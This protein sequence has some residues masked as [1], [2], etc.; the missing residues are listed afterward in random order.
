MR[1]RSRKSVDRVNNFDLTSVVEFETPAKLKITR[2]GFCGSCIF[3]SII[4]HL[5]RQMA[6]KSLLYYLVLLTSL[7]ID[8]FKK[9]AL[10]MSESLLVYSSMLWLGWNNNR[11]TDLVRDRLDFRSETL[12]LRCL[13]RLYC[14]VKFLPFP[15]LTGGRSCFFRRKFSNWAFAFASWFFWRWIALHIAM[16]P[17]CSAGGISCKQGRWRILMCLQRSKFLHLEF[18]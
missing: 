3:R 10:E 14:G 1:A 6:A 16:C 2:L 18:R 5:H 8:F 12:L 11:L 7:T 4:F 15:V 9:N 13:S 17:H